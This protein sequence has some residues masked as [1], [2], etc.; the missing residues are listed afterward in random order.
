MSRRLCTLVS[1][2]AACTTTPMTESPSSPEAAGSATSAE[3]PGLDYPATTR[4]DIV[5]TMHG[6]SVADPYRWLEDVDGPGVQDWMEAQDATAREYL[7]ALPR[8]DQLESRLIELTY[9]DAVSPPYHRGDKFF[10]SRSHADKEKS[11][12]YFK[13]GKDGEE[14]VFIDPNTLSEDGSISVSGRSPSPNGRYVA[15]KLNENNADAATMYVRD[16][17]TGKDSTV[18]VIEGARYASASWTPDNRGFYYVWLPT[19]DSISVAEMPGH[20][21]LRYH[22]LGTDPAKDETVYPAQHDATTFMGGSVSF[23]GHWLFLY[24][25]RGPRTEVYFKDLRSKKGKRKGFQPLV[26]GFTAQ[27]GVTTHDDR[28]Y[29]T[30]DEGAPHSRVFEVDPASPERKD[31]REIIPERD[32]AV[33]QYAYVVGG[34]LVTNYMV[35][36]RSELLVRDL[37]GKVVRKVELPGVGTTGGLIG[38]PDE[39]EA[40]FYYTSF[41]QP[42]MIYQTS[43]ST[44]ETGLWETIEYPVDTSQLED[45]QVWYE[46]ADGTKVSMFV[47]HKKGLKLDGS[48]PTLL[49]GYGGF[50]V[51]MTPAFSP[52]AAL[53]VENGGVY[54]VANL[55]GGGEYG[56]AWHEAGMRGQKQNVFDDFIAA[57]QFLVDEGYTMPRKLG[58]RGG[59]NGGL[60]VGAAMTQRPELFGAVVCAV[61]LLDMVR[62]HRFGSGRTWIPEYGDPD[63][64]EDFAFISAYSPYHRV[65]DGTDYPAMLMLSADSDDRVDPMHARKFTAAIQAASVSAEPAIM[66]IEKNAGH[67]GAGTRRTAVAESV[68]TYAFLLSELGD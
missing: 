10:Y 55:R 50:G 61:P 41:T 6:V 26:T 7:G 49:G 18:D 24:R 34:H 56:E 11:I 60:L 66:R 22:H 68:D 59:S 54:A 67:G 53:W 21:E 2:L 25:V 12:H 52:A 8:R 16:L 51:S 13:V 64:A 48:H 46:S 9:I 5:E 63:V 36:A 58:I 23:D 1:L 31:W 4:E 3:K 30:T 14:Q 42:P 57:A 62:Y 29:V 38:R 39:D 20:A 17:D 33:L 27:Y 35:N 40:Y 43:V 37:Q 28:F 47:V 44:G 19:D 15:Y 32:D 65:K 45:H